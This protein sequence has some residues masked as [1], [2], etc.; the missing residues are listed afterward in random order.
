MLVISTREFRAKQGKYLKLVKNGEEVILKS[1]ENGS[2]ALTPV[3]EYSTLIPKEYILKTKDEDLKRA[4]TGEELLERLI[5][6]VEKL[7]DK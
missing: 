3:T 5:P 4:I 7:F 2:F 6:R 1:R